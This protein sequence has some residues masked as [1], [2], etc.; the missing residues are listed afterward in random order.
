DSRARRRE[1]SQAIAELAS[2]RQLSGALDAFRQMEAE[3]LAPDTKAY[4]SLIN[5]HVNSGDGQGR[6]PPTGRR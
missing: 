4:G 5:A 2:K 3:G 6:L 1:L